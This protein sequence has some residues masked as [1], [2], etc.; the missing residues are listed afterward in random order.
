MKEKKKLKEKML[1]IVLGLAMVLTLAIGLAPMEA[2]AAEVNDTTENLTV[3]ITKTGDNTYQFGNVGAGTWVYTELYDGFPGAASVSEIKMSFKE[4]V[5]ASNALGGFS[6]E[7]FTLKNLESNT[8]TVADNINAV[9]LGKVYSNEDEYF[10]HCSEMCWFDLPANVGESA[11]SSL[12]GSGSTPAPTEGF[13]DEIDV[14]V[15]WSKVPNLVAG[16]SAMPSFASNPATVTGQ[17]IGDVRYG[18]AIKVDNSFKTDNEYYNE[19]IDYYIAEYGGWAPLNMVMDL[20]PNYRINA[21]DTYAFWASYMA[22]EGYNFGEGSGVA[23]TGTIT[24]NVDVVAS[25]SDGFGMVSFFKLGTLAEMEQTKEDLGI[26]PPPRVADISDEITVKKIGEGCYEISGIEEEDGYTWGYYL[27]KAGEG[28]SV[29]ATVAG[30]LAEHTG[31]EAGV[32]GTELRHVWAPDYE[33]G[34]AKYYVYGVFEDYLSDERWVDVSEYDIIEIFKLDA[35]EKCYIY[36]VA[37]LELPDT[38]SKGTVVESATI[39][40]GEEDPFAALVDGETLPSLPQNQFSISGTLSDDTS[41]N[42][43]EAYYEWIYREKGDEEWE[44]CNSNDVVDTETYEYGIVC[45]GYIEKGYFVEEDILDTFS[46]SRAD[47]MVDS[48]HVME[49]RRPFDAIEVYLAPYVHVH[50][51]TQVPAKAAT[52]TEIGNYA[53]YVCTTDGCTEVFEDAAGTTPTTVASKTIAALGHDWSGEWTTIKEATATETGKKETYC[54]NDC[55]QKKVVVIPATGTTEDEGSVEKDAEV[56]PDA[57][58]DEVT[59]NNTATELVENSDIFDD[60]EVRD[61]ANGADA[62]VW[63]EIKDAVDDEDKTNMEEAAQEIMGANVNITYFDAKLY[64]QVGTGNAVP[65]PEPGVDIKITIKI[66]AGLINT[67]A[68]IKRVYKILR[69]HEGE[70]RPTVLEGTFDAATGEFTFATDKFSTYAIV[71]EDTAVGGK[72]GGGNTTG[73]TTTPNNNVV[74]DKKDE[75]PK[76]GDVD[77]TM[78]AFLL[79]LASGA[80]LLLTKK[81]EIENKGI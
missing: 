19:E 50:S 60:D 2:R 13:I 49:A 8:I 40:V 9:V 42:T 14:Q 21:G 66:P 69:L 80:G 31:G 70:S 43:V 29:E 44:F 53:Y 77:T 7:T 22:Q 16:S 63:L 35:D 73:T 54:E 48:I 20:D 10:C 37:V 3:T 78:Y 51:L 64:K 1:S 58:I 12:G 56:A 47:V 72:P 57:P 15:D 6:K 62:R 71:Y 76:T 59:L 55:G 65:V 26:A 34:L 79:V 36:E 24:S 28:Q 4:F 45:M 67:N 52:C 11:T 68:S 75:V 32:W 23:Y 46:V 74:V 81:K 33:W 30:L 39:N 5:S 18:W 41:L 25:I 61:I 17:G 38:V 27:R